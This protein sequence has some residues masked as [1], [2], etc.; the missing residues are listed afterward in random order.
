M[1]TYYELLE[2]G[3]IGLSTPFEDVA[4][5]L[6]LTLTTEREIVNAWNNKRYFKG[7]EPPAPPPSHDKIRQLREE[8]FKKEADPLKYD[9]EEAVARYGYSSIEAVEAKTVWLEKKDEI[10]AKY[11]YPD[12]QS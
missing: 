5:S 4:K 10:R 6:G 3:T 8:A 11:P 7:D 1:I 2:D 9:Y 12:A